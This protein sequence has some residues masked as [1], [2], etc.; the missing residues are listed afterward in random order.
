MIRALVGSLIGSLIGLGSFTFIYFATSGETTREGWY[1][2][3][4]V[5][6]GPAAVSGAIVGATS[7][8]VNAIRETKQA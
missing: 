3:L 6:W 7:A 1:L 5:T 2:V 8:I 4:T